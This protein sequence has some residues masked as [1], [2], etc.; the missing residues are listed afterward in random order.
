MKKRIIDNHTMKVFITKEDLKQNG[1]T[2]LDL[3]GD[4]NQIEAFFYK[5][6]NEVDPQHIFSSHKPLTFR[7]I[8]NAMG[9]DIIISRHENF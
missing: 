4:H 3:L 6:L 2:A 8:P 7:V 1:I 9:L 5:V